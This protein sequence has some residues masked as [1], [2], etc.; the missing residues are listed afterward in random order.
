MNCSENSLYGARKRNGCAKVSLG[1]VLCFGTGPWSGPAAPESGVAYQY[2]SALTSLA[3]GG[4]VWAHRM[5]R[6]PGAARVR[7]S[8][9]HLSTGPPARTILDT[10]AQLWAL[11]SAVQSSADLRQHAD[12]MNFDL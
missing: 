8:W 6:T 11:F 10:L 5:L 1:N 12:A 4:D 9:V 2:I 3:M 7:R